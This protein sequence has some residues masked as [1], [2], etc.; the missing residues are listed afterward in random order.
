MWAA[1]PSKRA[2]PPWRGYSRA[3]R[4][5][6]GCAR[7]RGCGSHPRR[8]RRKG[9]SGGRSSSRV[10]RRPRR[11]AAPGV[12]VTVTR[13]APLQK[14]VHR[15]AVAVKALAHDGRDA[16]GA[17][18]APL[19]EILARGDVGD[20]HLDR[21]NADGLERVEQGDAGVCI[22]GGVEDDAVCTVII[23]LLDGV[24]ELAL[25]VRLVERDVY[26]ALLRVGANEGLQVF[27]GTAA[28]DPRLADAQHIEVRTVQNEN[29]HFIHSF[30]MRCAVSSTV[31]LP[32][33]CRSAAAQ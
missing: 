23:R 11:R 17:D 21:R 27:V 1:S 18:E 22:G 13:P 30:S 12:M 31:P 14:D 33:I 25:V 7:C 8:G 15:L 2:E 4:P 19:A 24:D 6:P 26:A 9:A 5:C 28:V 20:V 10:A 29:V 3:S 32:S 16:G